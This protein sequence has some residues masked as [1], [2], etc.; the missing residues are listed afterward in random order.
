MT[1]SIGLLTEHSNLLGRTDLPIEV[2]PL[3]KTPW[4]CARQV[5]ILQ[6]L[7]PVRRIA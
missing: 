2:F 7:T 4:A 1:I 3:L 5:R 6:T